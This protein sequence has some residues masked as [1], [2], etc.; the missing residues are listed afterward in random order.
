M[1][2]EYPF[3]A[4]DTLPASEVNKVF[5]LNVPFF[6]KAIGPVTV[7]VGDGEAVSFGASGQMDAFVEFIMT[8][9]DPAKDLN[10]DVIYSMSTNVSGKVVKNRF[11][12][13]AYTL[14]DILSSNSV[15]TGSSSEEFA[16]VTGVNKRS[17]KTYTTLKIPAGALSSRTELIRCIFSRVHDTVGS[18][19]TGNFQ[20][21]TM[22][23]YQTA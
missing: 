1:A 7:D 22:K 12:Y 14:T 20:L 23:F 8:N 2:D 3:A 6:H 4:G 10:I 17:D 5:V 18:N 13:K 9:F 15:T 21:H 11:K 16:T 19:H